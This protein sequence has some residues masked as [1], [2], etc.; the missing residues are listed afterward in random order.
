[1]PTSATSGIESSAARNPGQASH[2][3]SDP[4]TSTVNASTAVGIGPSRP[5]L[6][7]PIAATATM[8]ATHA[9]AIPAAANF[10][11]RGIAARLTSIVT[12]TATMAPKAIAAMTSSTDLLLGHDGLAIR[13]IENPA[14]L[15]RRTVHPS[16]RLAEPINDPIM[17]FGMSG[18]GPIH[19]AFQRSERNIRALAVQKLEH[20]RTKQIGASSERGA[21]SS[22]LEIAI[23]IGL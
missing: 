4:I 18:G 10:D 2:A 9:A 17:M 12:S 6:N 16:V 7:P 22:Q 5:G 1:M 3:T 14:S 8:V 11:V 21:H 13:R 19:R 23:V 15:E 20:G